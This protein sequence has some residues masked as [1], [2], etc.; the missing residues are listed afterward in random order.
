M[1]DT[2]QSSSIPIGIDTDEPLQITV[3]VRT[4]V[5]AAS[6]R[7]IDA[8]TERLQAL[9]ETPL[10]DEIQLEQWPPQHSVTD[11]GRQSRDELVRE[12]ENWATEHGV[13]LRPA[14]R[15][16]TVPS[17]LAGVHETDTRI[18]VPV[19]TLALSPSPA[20]EEIGGVVPYTVTERADTETTYTVSD[21]LDTAEAAV[22]N[23]NS[24][25]ASGLGGQSS[26][27]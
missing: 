12:F 14:I 18:R 24:G 2:T 15:R 21:W 17:S 16:Q 25:T 23:G 6:R 26:R 13:S 7:Q 22:T 5:S 19:I 4:N 27:A 11:G 20:D 10:V 9:S 3:Y 8:V 1:T